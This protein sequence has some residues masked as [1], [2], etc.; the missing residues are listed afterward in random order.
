VHAYPRGASDPLYKVTR[1]IVSVNVPR[2]G[3][4]CLCGRGRGRLANRGTAGVALCVGESTD[5]VAAWVPRDIAAEPVF[6]AYS[7]TKTFIAVLLL[8]LPEEGLVRLDDKLSRWF[9]R[10][11]SADAISLRQLLNHTAGLPDY[12][13]L[14]AYHAAVRD[15]PSAAWS[16]DRFAKET[17]DNGLSCSHPVP[18]GP[19]RTRATCS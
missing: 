13:E 11:V 15:S 12:G 10:I 18:A 5:P 16:F 4:T 7:V 14:A 2:G 1:R 6:L 9:P 17:F 8:Q 19:I 3:R